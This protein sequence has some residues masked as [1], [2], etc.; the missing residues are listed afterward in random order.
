MP[1]ENDL[2]RPSPG[3]HRPAISPEE[4]RRGDALLAILKEKWGE[5]RTCPFCG[6]SRWTVDAI[7]VGIPRL[8]LRAEIPAYLVRCENC[9]VEVFLSAETLGVWPPHPQ[10]PTPEVQQ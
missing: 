7:S 10:P 2:S 4:S 1:D 5:K 9:G 8:G 6:V 3:I